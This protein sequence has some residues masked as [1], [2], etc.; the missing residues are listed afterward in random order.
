MKILA[1]I[2]ALLRY[3]QLYSHGAHNV[4]T[5]R[6]FFEDHEFFGGLY[7]TYEGIYD[8][9]IERIIGLGGKVDIGEVTNMAVT[10]FQSAWGAEDASAMLSTIQTGEKKL[11]DLIEQAAK[12]EGFS[13]GTINMLADMS[14]KSEMRSYQIGQRIA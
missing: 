7:P 3:L 4:T 2:A 14:D 12:A 11:R 6:T 1:R 9:V 13:Q 8:G 10:Q 5:G